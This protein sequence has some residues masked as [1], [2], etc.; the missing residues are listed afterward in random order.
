M[1]SIVRSS[2]TPYRWSVSKVSLRRVANRE[3]KMPRSFISRD[4]FSITAACRRYLAPLI[5]GEDYPPYRNGLPRY[6]QLRNTPVERRLTG[7]FMIKS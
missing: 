7:K 1:P 4:G 5:G 2:D 3:R 6:A